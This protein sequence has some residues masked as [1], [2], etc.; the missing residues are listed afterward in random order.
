[1]DG[2]R[3][4]VADWGETVF[5]I[6]AEREIG[7]AFSPASNAS[8]AVPHAI[9]SGVSRLRPASDGALRL[10]AELEIGIAFKPAPTRRSVTMHSTGGGDAAWVDVSG[11]A[12][13]ATKDAARDVG[14]TFTPAPRPM[15]P[16]APMALD[17]EREIG[18][19]F[20]NSVGA[21]A[22]HSTSGLGANAA[23][24]LDAEREIGIAFHGEGPRP[25]AGG[26]SERE[27]GIAFMPAPDGVLALDAEREIGIAFHNSA[28]AATT[29]S[30]ADGPK[31][32]QHDDAELKL[33]AEREIGIAFH[34]EGPRPM[35][36]D[37]ELE[38]GIAF[39]P[40]ATAPTMRSVA[41][42]HVHTGSSTLKI[43]AE[44]EIGIAFS[45][46]PRFVVCVGHRR[47]QVGTVPANAAA[48]ASPSHVIVT[49]GGV[50]RP[51]SVKRF[52]RPTTT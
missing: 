13:K 37:A 52:V 9:G 10:E 28:S 39:S 26:Y 2:K 47:V 40:A 25:M 19:A 21:A 51:L 32:P 48:A 46:F 14:I 12:F 42:G 35:A 24:K 30:A 27:I 16:A 15:G 11:T 45:P 8:G 23:L 33:D 3:W 6:D 38:I 22:M 36:L 50:A 7:I 18:I 41:G 29:H 34:G 5:K 4:S 20:H 17:A 44:R 1:M 31:P 49:E 43:D